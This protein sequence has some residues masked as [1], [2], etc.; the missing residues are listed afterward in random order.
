[1]GTSIDTHFTVTLIYK[2]Y[3]LRLFVKSLYKTTIDNITPTAE[4]TNTT[5]NK[6]S[7]IISFFK[8]MFYNFIGGKSRHAVANIYYIYSWF[9][10][11][12]INPDFFIKSNI[13]FCFLIN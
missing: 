13:N 2:K 6:V 12:Q 8:L 11:R 3:Y 5:N 9:C 10:V 7:I 1:M 4:A